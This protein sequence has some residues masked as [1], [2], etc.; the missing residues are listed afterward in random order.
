M[1]PLH[2]FIYCYIAY[3]E[4]SEVIYAKDSITGEKFSQQK[5]H[6]FFIL[7]RVEASLE[8]KDQLINKYQTELSDLMEQVLSQ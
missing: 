4:T 6:V 3:N 1:E 7:Q 8:K 5:P 2:N